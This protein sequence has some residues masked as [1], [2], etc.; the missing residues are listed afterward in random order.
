MVVSK[1]LFFFSLSFLF[2]T[3]NY[4]VVKGS[5]TV[6]SVEPSVTF[7]S[8]DADNTM[9]G[10]GW[11]KNGFTL[12]DVLTTC[13]F[14]SVFPV[15][16]GI[17]LNGGTLYLNQDLILRDVVLYGLGTIVG[18]QHVISM[19]PNITQLASG[20]AQVESLSLQ[21]NSNID[22]VSTITFRGNCTLCGDGKVLTFHDGAGIFIDSG[23]VFELRDIE[24]RGLK[25]NAITCIDDTGTFILDDVRLVHSDTFSWPKGT[26]LFRDEVEL[27]G[28]CTFA[29]TSMQ[30]STIAMNAQVTVSNGMHICL[31]KDPVTQNNSLYFES[32][33]ATLHLNN[34]S[35]LA[36]GS[37]I[38]LTR[39]T[40]LL[41]NK[42]LIDTVGTSTQEGIILGEGN[43]ATDITVNV[44]PGA[45]LTHNSGYW[46]YNNAAVDKIQ[47]TSKTARMIRTINSRIYMPQNMML[48]NIT[49]EL[50]S[51]LIAPI[52]VETGKKL[53]YDNIGI[54][55]P[56]I[57]FDI[58]SHQLNAYTYLLDGGDSVFL[59]KGVLPL[60]LV[61][62]G[63]NNQLR[64]NGGV[65]GVITFADA[66]SQLYC[67]LNGFID[68][69]ILLNG[70]SL[71]LDYDLN[72]RTKGALHGPGVIDVGNNYVEFSKEPLQMT[73][74]LYWIGDGGGV[75]L[76]GKVTL[77]S[78]WTF[79]GTCRIN[80]NGAKLVLADGAGIYVAENSELQL[81]NIRITGVSGENI[82][83]VDDTGSIVL[84]QS[85]LVQSGD[86]A[87]KRG[88]LKF[89]LKNTLS[90]AYTFSYDSSMTS[91]VKSD[92]EWAITEYADLYIGRN[93]GNEP[94][95]FEDATSFFK[96][97]DSKFTVKNTG[98]NL[99]RGTIISSRD[100]QV[101]VQS[102]STQTGLV[103]G[104]GTP[105]G[106]MSLVLHASST[107]RFTGGHVTYNMSRNNGIRSK[108]TT[109]QM[110][111][112]A[113]SIFYL[114][115]DLDLA[116]LTIDVSPYSA[117]IVEPGKKLTYSNARV[118]NDQDEFYL[119]TTWYNFY[120]MLLAG[121]GVINLSN[122][123]LPLYLL[124]QGVG[125]RLEGVGNIG[126]LITLANSDAELLCDLSGS[127]LKS[128]S[129][130]GGIVSLNQNLKLG[131]GVVFA[132]GGMVN[133]NTFDIA[134]GNTDAAWSNDIWWNGTDAVIS[135]NS[136]VSL[137]STWTFNGTCAV[138]G[139]GHTLRLGSLG[140]IA[141]APNSQLILQDLYI[142]NIAGHNICC[143]DD[144]SSIILKNVHWG[145]HPPAG[146]SHMQDYS[147]S[148]T[149]GSLQFYNTVTIDGAA[150]FAYETSQTSTIARDSSLVLDH[151]ITFSYAP[152]GNC[153]LLELEN[154]N[155][156]F[157][158]NGASLYITSTGMQ[159][160]KGIFEIT[161]DSDVII[162]YIDIEDEYGVTNRSY[163]ELILG[164]G[165]TSENDC[166][167]M[168]QLGVSLRMRQ[169]ILSYKNLSFASWRMGNQLS[170]LTFYPGAMLT[171]YSSLPLGQGRVLI[172]KHAH[173]DDR[174]GNDIIGVVDI[175]EGLA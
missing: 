133:M 92:A 166:T 108:S 4:P 59:T 50:T 168:I 106:D 120:T 121:N 31:G 68:N 3:S 12:E 11:F 107:A 78:T 55:L 56:D 153:Q 74:P 143:L 2:F 67:G 7:P 18:N 43:A 104:D 142:E 146:Q 164:D 145:Q 58:T 26:I 159:L 139:K 45:A 27:L 124:V 39:G 89:F 111:R 147:Y 94:L 160:T 29:Y 65:A 113:G 154:D 171:L 114:P 128:I 80:G 135:L 100:A 136:N 132:G 118:V 60:Y 75:G 54:R 48:S 99:T 6:L 115:A 13:T 23:A 84:L 10:F 129:M 62:S 25:E 66:Q 83:C 1:R 140:S 49:V 9:L 95:Y 103:F 109:A 17:N 38:T 116:D 170:M 77:S 69:A 126:G 110:I 138:K 156:R 30:T 52:Q 123:T 51:P 73:T 42:V 97:E 5:E 33:N 151:G 157:V 131:N 141:V 163:G 24:V 172:S 127:L 175:V 137:A 101:D 16:G 122:G 90:G 174:G 72:L 44:L 93:Q 162:D 88:A 119:T 96:F 53:S 105:E 82:A 144:T 15:S 86:V 134:T 34:C 21:C 28:S 173:I 57:D 85:D 79:Q 8:A 35:F 130:N 169:G 14:D 155:S 98:M 81:K 70:G 148:F 112:S 47:S 64:G 165:I 61:I 46:V 71:F 125:N 150:I 117:L 32:K 87:F 41:E 161:E 22:L 40:L 37:G 20:G 152:D 63:A 19:S 91:T 102:T 36:T 167:G 149:T 76:N 158:L